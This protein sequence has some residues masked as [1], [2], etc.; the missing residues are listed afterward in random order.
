MTKERILI[1]DDEQEIRDL[2]EIYLKSEGYETVKAS[3]GEEA[4]QILNEEDF[5]LII[6]DIMMPKLNGI[7]ACMKIREERELPIIMLSAKSEDMDKI[8]GLNTG[9][10]DYLTKPFYMEELKARIN[11]ILKSMGKIK[12]SNILEFKDMTIDMKMKK[13]FIGS[14]EIEFN[15]KL[16]TLLEYLIK[17]KGIIL[18]KEQIFDNICGYDSDASTD[19]IEVYMSRLRKKLSP[20][21]YDKYIITKRGMGYLVD[22]NVKE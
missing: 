10:D 21:G 15:E 14:E 19:I 12:N 13:V 5:D 22:E 6:L 2:I 7:D 18:F 8:L 16:Y 17:N 11:A 3:N 9:A 4:L 1:V 20:Y